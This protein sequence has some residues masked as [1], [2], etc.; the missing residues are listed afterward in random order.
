MIFG[1]EL[2]VFCYVVFAAVFG[3]LRRRSPTIALRVLVAANITLLFVANVVLLAYL[4][5]QVVLVLVLYAFIVKSRRGK[6]SRHW[7]WLAFLGLLPVTCVDWAGGTAGLPWLAGWQRVSM[8]GVFWNMGATFFV[9]KSFVILREALA[10]RRQMLLP[11]A[12]ALTFLPAF[13]AGPIHGSAVWSPDNLTRDIGAKVWFHSVMRIG[14][15]AAAFYVLA[16]RVKHLGT[17]AATYPIGH[18]ADIYLSFASLY[19]DFSGYTAMAL[20]MAALFG[21]Q[22]PENFDRP[23]LATSVREFWRR[24]HISLSQFIGQYLFKP[25]VRST[26]S[27]WLGITLAFLFTGMWHEVSWR[28][29]AWGAA[30]GLAMSASSYRWRYWEAV[31]ARL[32]PT[33]RAILGWATTMTTVAT[34]SYLVQRART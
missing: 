25:M 19:L 1:F 8:G 23:Y 3:L 22:L 30:H 16:P 29:L 13:S 11:A 9:I 14:W 10:G 27:K 24:W 20:A 4:A 15:G 26:G 5:I 7:A 28:Y 6:R 34:I 21:A 2:T 12:A 18:M 17:L 31:S 33:V 32:H